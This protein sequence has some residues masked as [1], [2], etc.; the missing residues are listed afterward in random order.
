[1]TARFLIGEHF[2]DRR[3]PRSGAGHELALSI[4]NPPRGL[5]IAEYSKPGGHDLPRRAVVMRA[6]EPSGVIEW[7]ASMFIGAR[8]SASAARNAGRDRRRP[9]QSGIAGRD[10]FVL[11]KMSGRCFYPTW[12]RFLLIGVRASNCPSPVAVGGGYSFFME[13][14]GNGR[15]RAA[16]AEIGGLG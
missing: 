3:H 4:E 8:E 2:I 5:G 12:C 16:L 13:A 10:V 7:L 1:L 6:M 14:S 9:R 15:E 11:A